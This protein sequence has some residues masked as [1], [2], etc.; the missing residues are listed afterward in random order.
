MKK[1][2][3]IIVCLVII[4]LISWSNAICMESEKIKWHSYN[5]GVSLGEKQSKKIFVTFYADWCGY[6]KKMD[7]ETFTNASVV[8]YLANNYVTVKV[9]TQKEKTLASKF[10]ISGLPSHMFLSEKGEIIGTQPGYMAADG[11]LSLLKYV[12]TDSYKTMK[13]QDF[14]ESDKK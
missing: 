13:L 9:D 1:N 7:K 2:K 12:K 3:T 14:I 11:F 5:D 4:S 6:C 10:R 8:N